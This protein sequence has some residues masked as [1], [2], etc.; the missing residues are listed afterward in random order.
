MVASEVRLGANLVLCGAALVSLCGSAYSNKHGPAD[1]PAEADE[2]GECRGHCG[3]RGPVLEG[4]DHCSPP[5]PAVIDQPFDANQLAA[6]NSYSSM[7]AVLDE[8][9]E[10]TGLSHSLGN[11]TVTIVS[12]KP[13]IIVVDDFITTAE[14]DHL[15]STMSGKAL[16]TNTVRVD[17]KRIG[18]FSTR[19]GPAPCKNACFWR[20]FLTPCCMCYLDAI[21]VMKL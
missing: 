1:A 4:P 5:W 9:R 11:A 13:R 7:Q 20:R 2:T 12:W 14:A 8:T 17:T 19:Y 3:R 18:K 10:R 16:L 15:V 21:A 6:A